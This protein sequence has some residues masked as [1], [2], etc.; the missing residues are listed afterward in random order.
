[1]KRQ[2]GMSRSCWWRLPRAERRDHGMPTLELTLVEVWKKRFP[3]TDA[4]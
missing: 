3:L 4:L 1:M 2:S